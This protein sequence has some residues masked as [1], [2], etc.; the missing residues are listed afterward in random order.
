MERLRTVFTSKWARALVRSSLLNGPIRR[1]LLKRA[2]HALT[3]GYR[4]PTPYKP[5]PR[6]IDDK[7]RMVLALLRAVDHGLSSGYL[8]REYW[9]KLF[10]SFGGIFT[11]GRERVEAFK[12]KYGLE[13][14]GF[15]TISPTD[16]CN[17]RC[18]GCYASSSE[19]KHTKLSYETFSRIVREQKELWGSHFTVISGGEPFIY[20][21][22]G[23]TLLDLAAEHQDTFFQVFTNGTLISEKVAEKLADVGNITPA[24]SVEGFAEQTDQRRGKGVHKRIL[25]GM[26]NLRQAG[27]PFGIS[28]TATSKNVDILLTDEFWDFYFDQQGALYSWLFQYMPVG[29]AYTLSL[30][31]SPEKRMQLYHH[32]WRHVREKE[33]FIADF[34]NSGTVSTGCIAAGVHGG[35]FHILWDGQVTPCVFN[36]YSTDNINDVYARGDNLDCVLFSPYFEGIRKWQRAYVYDRPPGEMGNVIAPCPIR[37]HYACLYDIIQETHP[38]PQDQAAAEAIQDAEY[39]KGLIDYGERF[40]KVSDPVWRDVYLASYNDAPQGVANQS[41]ATPAYL[42]RTIHLVHEARRKLTQSLRSLL[43]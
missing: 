26:E 2:A 4:R 36:H 16:H 13:P 33:R 22:K 3:N 1:L 42:A 5:P 6:V 10:D 9:N 17:L 7:Y 34:W 12:A 8:S 30:M 32:V 35:Y 43:S 38:T 37:D 31:I 28:V 41:R 23:R 24:I 27:V 21:D 29:R 40:L 20:R 25:K 19:A 14:P 39:R 15:I 18:E 11:R